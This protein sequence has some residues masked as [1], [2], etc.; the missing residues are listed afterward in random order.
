MVQVC[1][2]SNHRRLDCLLSRLI[3][4]SSKKT[5]KLRITD[6]SDGI[7]RRPVDSPHKR[8]VTWKWCPFDDVI[9]WILEQM[10]MVICGSQC[11][12]AQLNISMHIIAISAIKRPAE[13]IEIQPAGSRYKAARYCGDVI[14]WKHFPRYW[15]FKRQSTGYRWIP[16]TKASD[17]ELWYLFD[18]CL[19]KQLSKQSRRRFLEVIA[20]L[21]TSL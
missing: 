14:K 11:S 7:H 21:M 10:E 16:L 12:W 6:L 1:G 9:M 19:N 20:L 13:N 18:M 17:A 3:R 15:P 4:H 5:L 2:V 8:P